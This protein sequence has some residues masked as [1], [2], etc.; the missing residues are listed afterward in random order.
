[1]KARIRRTLRRALVT[2]AILAAIGVGGVYATR[3][4]RA[5]NLKNALNSRPRFV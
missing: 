1:M 4:P 5:S 2:G 3:I